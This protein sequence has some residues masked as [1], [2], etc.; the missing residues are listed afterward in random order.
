MHVR[1]HRRRNSREKTF[2]KR[3][4]CSEVGVRENINNYVFMFAARFL[5]MLRYYISLRKLSGAAAGTQLFGLSLVID[6]QCLPCQ[7]FTVQCLR[8]VTLC[9]RKR[10]YPKQQRCNSFSC[11]YRNL[12]VDL[13][14]SYGI[15]MAFS[16]PR[17]VCN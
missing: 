7:F 5:I 2:Q 4:A 17:F 13:R 12:D 10:A 9:N 11:Q 1:A 6:F 16:S 8:I 15:Y 14:S 3:P